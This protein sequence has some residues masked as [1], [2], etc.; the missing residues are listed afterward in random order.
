MVGIN[1]SKNDLSSSGGSTAT[2][3]FMNCNSDDSN[4]LCRLDAA[5]VDDADVDGGVDASVTAGEVAD[6]DRDL[7]S[8]SSCWDCE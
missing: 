4:S 7:S 2:G 3:E 1:E 6:S 8:S 5:P